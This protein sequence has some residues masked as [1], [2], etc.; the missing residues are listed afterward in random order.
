MASETKRRKSDLFRFSDSSTSKKWGQG[1]GME[2]E[3][4][5]WFNESDED[6]TPSPLWQSAQSSSPLVGK[7]KRLPK[8][9]WSANASNGRH[10]PTLKVAGNKP[11]PL[12]DYD[13]DDENVS[14]TSPGVDS[15]RVSLTLRNRTPA[16]IRLPTLDNEVD[17]AHVRSTRSNSPEGSSE[18]LK[19]PRLGDKRRRE[20][21]DDEMFERL[22]HKGKR[23]SLS[24]ESDA[25]DL[26]LT[27][28]KSASSGEEGT[29]KFK[30]K[31]ASIGL[32]S[33]GSDSTAG[34]EPG[35]KDG[36]GG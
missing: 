36:D 8:A 19:I 33:V 23:Q 12:V 34:S 31:I 2:D 35:A 22:A 28:A 16:P 11:A 5:E 18:E 27:A 32:N 1:R 9:G 15:S 21:D 29:K 20:E 10:T 26:N 24:G 3:E 25:D 7:R 17:N 14:P 30:L 13:E 4:E 6:E